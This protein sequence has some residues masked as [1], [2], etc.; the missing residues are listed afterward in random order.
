MVTKAGTNEIHGTAYEFTRVSTISS[1]SYFYNANTLPKSVF[2]RNQFGY[3]LGGPVKKNKLFFF[4]ST[5]WIRIRSAAE[6]IAYVPTSQFLALTAANTQAFF[7]QYGK[8]KSNAAVLQNY[9]LNQLAATG[10]TGCSTSCAAI[11]P[12][13]PLLSELGI[14]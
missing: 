1:N 13:L 8:L 2:D 11:N 5:E 12:N 10:Q 9:R 14:R 3:S 4:S 6:E 7:N